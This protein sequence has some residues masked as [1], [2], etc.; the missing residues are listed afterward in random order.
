MG[1]GTRFA[2]ASMTPAQ[3]RRWERQGQA[4]AAAND[5]M[6][7]IYEMTGMAE[8]AARVGDTTYG[9]MMSLTPD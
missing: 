7:T 3:Q 8:F 6:N 2:A 1:L 9:R 5:M 4:T